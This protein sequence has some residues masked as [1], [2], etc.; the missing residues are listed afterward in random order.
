MVAYFHEQGLDGMA[1][2]MRCQAHEEMNKLKKKKIRKKYHANWKWWKH[3]K[4]AFWCWIGNWLRV[5]LP[6]AHLLI[7]LLIMLLYNTINILKI[8]YPYW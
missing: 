6:Q 5:F 7:R 8:A 2:R 1:H 4:K 3:Q